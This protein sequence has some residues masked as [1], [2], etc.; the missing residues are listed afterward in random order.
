MPSLNLNKKMTLFLLGHIFLSF[1]L[2]I[3]HSHAAGDWGLHGSLGGGLIREPFRIAHPENTC[4][5]IH[6]P[7]RSTPNQH[8][9]H[10]ILQDQTATIRL[11]QL[12]F[13]PAD[14][15]VV[16]A[17]KQPFPLFKIATEKVAWHEF[18]CFSRILLAVHSGLSPPSRL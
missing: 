18:L 10:F 3:A 1:V 17:E 12:G 16:V 13:S 11:T 5:E 15:P 9:L 8:H 7:G 4:C 6:E 2:P 14:E